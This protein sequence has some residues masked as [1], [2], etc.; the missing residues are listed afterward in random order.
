[1]KELFA[2]TTSKGSSPARLSARHEVEARVDAD[3]FAR[4]HGKREVGSERAKAAASFEDTRSFPSVGLLVQLLPER[5]QLLRAFGDELAVGPNRALDRRQIG[6][7]TS[8]GV[9]LRHDLGK[10]RRGPAPLVR[11]KRR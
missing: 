6:R 5:R 11:E 1:M 7:P 2:T 4:S 8:N 10:T 9:V 3:D